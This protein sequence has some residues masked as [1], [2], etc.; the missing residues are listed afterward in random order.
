MLR[1][2]LVKFFI[3][4]IVPTKDEE[5]AIEDCLKSI[6]AQ[7]TQYP[8]EVLVVD[9]NSKDKTLEIA[10]RHGAR[11]IQESRPG[12]PIARNTG[13]L[14]AKG[15]I[16]CFT[17]ADCQV[18]ET[19]VETIGQTFRDDPG[20]VALSG[21][22]TLIKTTWF[23]RWLIRI[24]TPLSVYLFYIFF[25]YHSLRG[26]NLAVRKSAFNEVGGFN[27]DMLELDDVDF[28]MRIKNLG[29]IRYLSALSVRTLDRRFRNRLGRFLAEFTRSFYTVCIRRQAIK[30][31]VYQDVR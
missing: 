4:I 10:K 17:E 8:F 22:Y 20:V 27:N 24:F 30:G 14:Q 29:R 19:W 3:S 26:T 5:G 25:G 18:P 15:N 12:K 23:Y 31:S 28:G 6:K 9:T 1:T 7:R 13:S 2:L 16:L 11:I 21:A